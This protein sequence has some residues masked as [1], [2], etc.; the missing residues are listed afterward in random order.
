[1]NN[2]AGPAF[3]SPAERQRDIYR[4]ANPWWR[5]LLRMLIA[6]GLLCLVGVGL[7][8]GALALQD[9]MDRDRL[10]D[11]GVES[12]DFRSTTFT[13]HS[14]APS[15]VIDGS[16]SIDLVTGAFEFVGRPGGEQDG[17]HVVSADGAQ[18]FVRYGTGSWAL[19]DGSGLGARVRNTI[20][21]LAV[22]DADHLLPVRLRDGFLELSGAERDTIEA[23][24]DS[25]R[26]ITRYDL[27]ID[28][29]GFADGYPVQY[30][31]W[32][33]AVLPS[34]ETS[35]AGAVTIWIDDH[36]V[37]VG[38]DDSVTG[39]AWD[40]VRYSTTEFVPPDPTVG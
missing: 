1:M 9:W 35:S 11:V 14:A 6:T 28:T 10:P 37:V 15:T 36:E 5:R 16:L 25:D 4:K 31:A 8:V 32:R 34:D 24:D 38:V 20:T 2:L 29:K 7:Y 13:V 3:R 26:T 39:W 17:L 23:I 30:R 40:R 33:D 19:D 18:V 27:V 12:A 21:L 22:R